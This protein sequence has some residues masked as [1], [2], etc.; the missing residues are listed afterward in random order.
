MCTL[1]SKNKWEKANPTFNPRQYDLEDRWGQIKSTLE[2][3]P[4]NKKITLKQDREL[5]LLPLLDGVQEYC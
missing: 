1:L 5:L 3:K 2:E 4:A